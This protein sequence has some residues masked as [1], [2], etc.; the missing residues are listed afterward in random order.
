MGFFHKKSALLIGVGVLILLISMSGG[1]FTLYLNHT[2]SGDAQMINEMGA[3]RGSIQRLVKLERAG[4]ANDPLLMEIDQKIQAISASKESDDEN[5]DF[6]LE[7]GR[8]TSSW[9]KLRLRIENYRQSPIYE[10]EEG[11]IMVS[12]EAW[13]NANSMV[14]ASQLLSERKVENFR[15]SLIFT[16]LN[17]LLG[18]AILYLVQKYV[19]ENLEHGIDHDGL[20]DLY[21]RRFFEAFLK[22]HINRSERYSTVFSLILLDIDHFKIINDTHGHDVG[23]LV[24]MELSDLVKA[25]IRKADIVAR[26]GGEEFAIVAT[27]TSIEEACVLAEKTRVLIEGHAFKRVGSVTVSLG[28]AQYIVGDEPKALY[29]RADMALYKAKMGG[30]N[31][32]ETYVPALS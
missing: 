5:K 8:L 29:K 23:D 16:V 9:E 11:M 30:R 7:V 10:H 19:K 6:L 31:R 12:E 26:V 1:M 21:N 18:I 20:T 2:I 17:L 14:L 4:R 32:T 22:N 3:V 25:N 28:I 24:L 13:V 15:I 27:E